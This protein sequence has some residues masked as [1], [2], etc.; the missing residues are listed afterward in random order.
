MMTSKWFLAISIV[1]L[2]VGLAIPTSAETQMREII[3]GQ[4]NLGAGVCSPSQERF[5]PDFEAK[6]LKDATRDSKG[7]LVTPWKTNPFNPNER[8]RYLIEECIYG[9]TFIKETESYWEGAV[10]GNPLQEEGK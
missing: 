6:H 10:F 1:A 7:R 2:I 4:Q 3:C 8:S 9:R 5:S